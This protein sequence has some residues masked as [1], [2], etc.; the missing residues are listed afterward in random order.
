[1]SHSSSLNRRSPGG[2]WARMRE[3]SGTS[4]PA[5]HALSSCKYMNRPVPETSYPSYSPNPLKLETTSSIPEILDFHAP[6]SAFF[7]KS[8]SPPEKMDLSGKIDSPIFLTSPTNTIPLSNA[9]SLAETDPPACSLEARRI[10]KVDTPDPVQSP[11]QKK[12]VSQ[13]RHNRRSSF[14]SQE[15]QYNYIRN[16]EQS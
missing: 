12:K 14:C 3:P 8:N 7:V 6:G 16:E 5:S 15:G 2:P 13:L 4:P 10:E 9:S 11:I 1:M